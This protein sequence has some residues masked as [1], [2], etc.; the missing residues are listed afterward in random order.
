M[1]CE[2]WGAGTVFLYE[3][4]VISNFIV[5]CPG[6]LNKRLGMKPCRGMLIELNG[7][8]HKGFLLDYSISVLLELLLYKRM[9]G[10]LVFLSGDEAAWVWLFVGVVV[11]KGCEFWTKSF[12]DFI[13]SMRGLYT[14]TSVWVWRVHFW[15]EFS[16][17]SLLVLFGGIKVF[18]LVFV[19]AAWFL[20]G[21]GL[22]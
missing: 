16:N 22:L 6:R 2:G 12:I 10:S 5:L 1:G 9:R 20:C 15:L 17:F 11:E 19:L 4:L 21:A 18:G 8:L 7:V 13:S 3:V 14:G